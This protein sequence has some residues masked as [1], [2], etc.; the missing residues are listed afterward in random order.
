M[1]EQGLVAAM[2]ILQTMMESAPPQQ[3]TMTPAAVV[4][5]VMSVVTW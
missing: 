3:V 5:V 2:M 4:F 1:V